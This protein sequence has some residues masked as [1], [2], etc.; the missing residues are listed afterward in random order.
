MA[1]KIPLLIMLFSLIGA[2]TYSP[3]FYL[4]F[5]FGFILPL[6]QADLRMY[7]YPVAAIAKLTGRK[8]NCPKCNSKGTMFRSI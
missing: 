7:L 2:I 4:L 3:Y 1:A 6:A 5:A 8:L